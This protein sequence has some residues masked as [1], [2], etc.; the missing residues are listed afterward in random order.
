[1]AISTDIKGVEKISPLQGWGCYYYTQR[2]IIRCKPIRAAS[3][4]I[5]PRKMG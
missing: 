3:N 4:E 5:K 2:K 1:M